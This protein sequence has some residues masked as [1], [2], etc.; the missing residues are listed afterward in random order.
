MTGHV[1]PPL[2]CALIKLVDIPELEYYASDGKG[3]ICVKGPVVFKGYFKDPD[4]TSAVI[5]KD[6]WL[7]TGDIGQWTAVSFMGF[8]KPIFELRKQYIMNY[9]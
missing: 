3:E 9:E 6:G 5:D 1:G 2:A 7:R 4:K 8:S